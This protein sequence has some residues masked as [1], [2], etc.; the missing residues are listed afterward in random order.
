MAIRT[1]IFCDICNPRGIR[2]PETR[3][4]A[5]RDS[6]LRGR[7]VSDSRAWFEGEITDAIASGWLFDPQGRHVCPGCQQSHQKLS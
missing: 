6:E 5:H 3:Q 7:R 4:G 1:F 2:T